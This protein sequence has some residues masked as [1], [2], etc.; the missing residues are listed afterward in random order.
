MGH[1]PEKNNIHQIFRKIF[2][3]QI[4]KRREFVWYLN[5]LPGPA[6][7]QTADASEETEQDNEDERRE[8]VDV[9]RLQTALPRLVLV[10]RIHDNP[11]ITLVIYD[12]QMYVAFNRHIP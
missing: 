7:A 5:R 3:K 6:A 10:T 8:D 12:M 1:A 4:K 9:S 2:E 11:L